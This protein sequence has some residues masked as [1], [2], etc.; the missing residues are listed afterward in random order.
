MKRYINVSEPMFNT[1]ELGLDAV[2]H[3]IQA[4]HLY[5]TDRAQ[6]E[7]LA[8]D[9]FDI[10]N[11]AYDEIGGFKSF[12]DMEHF[13][14]DSYLWY[15]TYDGVVPNDIEAFDINKLYA[16]SVFRRSHGL[17]MVGMAANRFPNYS[18]GSAA[19]TEVK[20]KAR[21]AILEHI[22]FVAN[23]GWAEV[24]DRLEKLFEQALP[25][26]KYNIMPE[27][28]IEHKVFKD[29]SIDIDG[30]HYYRP[31]R[32]NDVTIRKIAYGTIRY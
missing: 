15:I 11:T 28:L 14:N 19:R 1:V 31:L 24:S 20:L 30:V 5:I 8:S 12:K 2:C 13:I 18:K 21:A 25:W 10:L 3:Y 23:R 7:L 9:I 4:S 17:K 26:G 29:I 6:R 22:R 32:K 27:D 16:V